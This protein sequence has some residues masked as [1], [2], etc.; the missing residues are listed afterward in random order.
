MNYEVLCGSSAAA[1][2]VVL[3]AGE[4]ITAE[5]GVHVVHE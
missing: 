2:K 1:L 5:G 4:T 3:D